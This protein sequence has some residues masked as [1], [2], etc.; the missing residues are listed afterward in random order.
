MADTSRLDMAN[1]QCVFAEAKHFSAI[2]REA[3][4]FQDQGV[5]QEILATGIKVC[6]EAA[7]T[8]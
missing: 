5:E 4:S 3:P 1:T 8:V 7:V 6:A 2:H